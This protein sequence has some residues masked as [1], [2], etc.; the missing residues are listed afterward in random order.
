MKK[1]VDW[2]ER[3][4]RARALASPCVLCHR[5]CGAL[6]LQ[7]KRG[8]CGV[9]ERVHVYRHGLQMGEEVALTPS[10]LIYLCGCNL[11]CSF[12]SEDAFLHAPFRVK[13][14][15]PEELVSDIRSR[16]GGAEPEAKNLHFVGGEPILHLPFLME[17]GR[18]LDQVW[19]GHPPLVFNTNGTFSPEAVDLCAQVFST[20]VVDLKYGSDGCAEAVAGDGGRGYTSSVRQSLLNLAAQAGSATIIVRHLVLPGHLECCSAPILRWL[21]AELPEVQVNVMDAFVPFQGTPAA[22]VW[23]ELTAGERSRAKEMI[24]EAGIV[25]AL[26]NGGA[27]LA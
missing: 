14:T 6:R 18:H 12:C 7:G 23:A 16:C 25:H 11:R 27:L 26:W 8:V 19:P 3:I 10:Y 24:T 2:E 20:F 21:A 13:P 1:G 4:A 15:T 9:D 5:R 17:L 22:Q